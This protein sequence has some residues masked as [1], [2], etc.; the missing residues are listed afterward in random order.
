[1]EALAKG[2]LD[3]CNEQ[4]Y[5]LYNG[6]TAELDYRTSGYGDTHLNWNAVM[7][8][9]VAPQKQFFGAEL[10]PGQ[11]LVAFREKS[12]RSNGLTKAR[13]IVEAVYLHQQGFTE[14]DLA[15]TEQIIQEFN[16]DPQNFDRQVNPLARSPLEILDKIMG[17]NFLEQVLLPWHD[18]FP[19]ITRELARPSTLYGNL[20]YAA[21]NGIEGKREID[22]VAAAHISGGGLPEKMARMLEERGLGA[23]LDKV[24]P[25]PEGVSQL[26]ELSHRLPE[27][28]RI[29]LITD[30]TAYH[31]WNR[32]IGFVVATRTDDDAKRLV[33]L[34]T[35]LGYEAA[36]AGAILPEPKL[37]IRNYT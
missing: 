33:D 20:M 24:F 12:I 37:E 4:G 22:I 25:D 36:I 26:L 30:Q 18:A 19:D 8:A 35:Y 11:P 9:I 28:Q 27:E 15:V 7:V 13:A 16:L 5:A 2:A 6:E 3:A 29:K 32:G 21:Q 14:K 10:A 31:Q 23:H 17:H 1:M 34:S